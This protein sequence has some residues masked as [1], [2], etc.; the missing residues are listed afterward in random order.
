[1]GRNQASAPRL[2]RARQRAA[3]AFR[4]RLRRLPLRSRL[5][6]AVFGLLA[7]LLVGLGVLHSIAE[8]RVLLHD[9]ASALYDEARLAAPGGLERGGVLIGLGKQPLPPGTTPPNF[10]PVAALVAQRLTGPDTSAA[11]LDSSGTVLA[12]GDINIPGYAPVAPDA[13]TVHRA[14]TQSVKTSGYALG[15]DADGQRQLYILLPI[16]SRTSTVGL[17]ELATRTTQIDSSVATTRLILLGGIGAAL[18]LAGVLA[19]PLIGAALRPLRQMER[20]SRR[21]AGGALSLRLQEPETDDEIGRLAHSF[22]VMVAQLEEAFARQ[23]RFVSDVSHELRTPLTALGGGLEMLLLGADAG[24]PE[25]Q[26]RLLR[27]MYAETERMRRLVEDLLT[28]ARLD[29]GRLPLRLTALDAV[30]LLRDVAE[31]AGRLAEGQ[32]IILDVPAAVLTVYADGDRLRQVLLNLVDNALKFT[33]P[34]RSVTL[35]AASERSAKDD[36]VTIAVRDT[37]VGIA[38]EALPHVFD[39]FY[40]ADFARA[41]AT[42][43]GGSGLGLAIARSLVEAQGGAISISS[44]LGQGTTVSITL[45]AA[46]APADDAPLDAATRPAEVESEPPSPTAAPH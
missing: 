5:A 11:V 43:P 33:P 7:V 3:E 1:M 23:K 19:L 29:E 44:A 17:L 21:I 41:R 34:E 27:G 35:A 9:R 2:S 26:R 40:R 8:E 36:S 31:Q 16:I 12:E 39:R 15:D 32:T 38:P 6:L 45:P 10:V 4:S 28:L 46:P 37:G 22:N 30:P 13:A 25:A 18:L 42:Q 14:L 24:D 20:A